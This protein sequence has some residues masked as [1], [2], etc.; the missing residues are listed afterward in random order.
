M[1][2]VVIFFLVNAGL[3]GGYLASRYENS[4]SVPFVL[5][6]AFMLPMLVIFRAWS[7][8]GSPRLAVRVGRGVAAAAAT[9]A[10][11]FL[12]VEQVNPTYLEGFGL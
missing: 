6:A 11:A 10:L 5:F 8:V 3:V 2:A 7:A 12:V 1:A 4:S 9:V